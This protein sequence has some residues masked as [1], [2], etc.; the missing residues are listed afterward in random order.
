MTTVARSTG[1]SA[2]ATWR[3]A[4]AITLLTFYTIMEQERMQALKDR[5]H[6]LDQALLMAM[7]WSDPSLLDRERA[8]IQAEINRDEDARADPYAAARALADKIAKG[9][10]V[11]ATHEPPPVGGSAS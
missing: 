11:T 9:V 8:E 3:E 7:A 10:T 4:Y 6:R 1:Q 2:R 5:S